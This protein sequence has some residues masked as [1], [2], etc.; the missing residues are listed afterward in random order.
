[1]R[2]A[3]TGV[4]LDPRAQWP[5][6]M[7]RLGVPVRGKSRPQ[8]AMEPGRA[9]ARLTALGWGQ[10]LRALPAEEDAPVAPELL[11]AVVPVLAEWG[12]S[13]RPVAVIA[14][15]SRRRPQLVASLAS[16]IAEMGRLTD[17]GSLDYAHDGPTGEPGG[18]SAFRLA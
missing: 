6:G 14:M 18:N 2:L 15:P 3:K 16:G 9:L 1:T 17:L 12:W 13:I 10:R 8:E 4:E 11:R 7:D 5:T